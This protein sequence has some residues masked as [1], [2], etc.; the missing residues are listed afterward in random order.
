MVASPEG[1]KKEKERIVKFQNICPVR[2]RNHFHHT[3]I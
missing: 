3:N 1:L 2:S